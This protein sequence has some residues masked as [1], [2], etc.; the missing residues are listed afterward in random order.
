MGTSCP[1]FFPYR[2]LFGT[3]ALARLSGANSK[4]TIYS[5]ISYRRN[6]RV[7][8]YVAIVNNAGKGTGAPG[9]TYK[10]DRRRI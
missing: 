8:V 4:C 6:E 7:P 5:Q 9:K 3:G 1:L 2:S 10:L